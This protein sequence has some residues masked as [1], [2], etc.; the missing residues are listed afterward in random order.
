MDF[1]AHCIL[2]QDAITGALLSRLFSKNGAQCHLFCFVDTDDPLNALHGYLST[3]ASRWNGEDIVWSNFYEDDGGLGTMTTATRPIFSLNSSS[4]MR[5]HLMGV[6]G[7]D[8]LVSRLSESGLSYQGV[9]GKVI[10]GISSCN[11]E[12]LGVCPMQVKSLVVFVVDELPQYLHEKN[13]NEL[14]IEHSCYLVSY[15]IE[16]HSIY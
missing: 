10:N 2:L 13:P 3:V 7:H 15:K 8:V 9:L 6:V 16:M 5:G 4:P 12:D 1:G 14:L 11:V